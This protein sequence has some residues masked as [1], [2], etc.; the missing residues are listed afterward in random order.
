M[1]LLLLKRFRVPLRSENKKGK[2]RTKERREE[3]VETLGMC[4]CFWGKSSCFSFTDGELKL[5]FLP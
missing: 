2:K 1:S 3:D 5:L 4:T